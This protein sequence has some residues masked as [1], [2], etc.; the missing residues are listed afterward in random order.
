MFEKEV[1]PYAPVLVESMRSLG[2]SFESAVADLIDNSIS[3]NAKRIDI[4]MIPSDEPTLMIIDDGD[5]MSSKEL[6]EA[7]RYGSQNPLEIRG[8]NDLGRF[9]LG[10]KSASL[11]QCRELTVTSKKN[12]KLSGFAWKLDHIINT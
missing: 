11:S 2:Y 1:I 7:M 4:I 9:G 12:G 6:Q 5:G 8:E 10:L 3:A